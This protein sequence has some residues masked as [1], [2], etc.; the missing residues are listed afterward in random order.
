M[1]KTKSSMTTKDRNPSLVEDDR[2]KKKGGAHKVRR[3]IPTVCSTCQGIGTIIDIN[4]EEMGCP[5]CDGLGE[6][7]DD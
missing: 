6:I 4:G 7:Y 2:W 3:P 5:E 1:G